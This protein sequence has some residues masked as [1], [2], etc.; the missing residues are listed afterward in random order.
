MQVEEDWE[1][2]SEQENLLIKADEIELS[3]VTDRLAQ[4]KHMAIVMK[5]HW[6]GLLAVLQRREEPADRELEAVALRAYYK[7][8]SFIDQLK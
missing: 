5:N 8:Q 2:I 6:A 1:Y 4:T 7:A 3:I